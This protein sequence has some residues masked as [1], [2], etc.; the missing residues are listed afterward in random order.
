ML[1]NFHFVCGDLLF[2]VL[3]Q[4]KLTVVDLADWDRIRKYRWI[5][6]RRRK[7]FYACTG[8]FRYEGGLTLVYLHRV[9]TSY[10]EVDHENRDGLDNTQANLREGKDI[11]PFNKDLFS[12][13]TSGYKGVIWDSPRWEAK[14]TYH[15]IVENLGHFDDPIEAAREY[16]AAVR[17]YFPSGAYQNFP[18]NPRPRSPWFR[19]KQGINLNNTTGFK[20]VYPKN[21]PPTIWGARIRLNGK[22]KYLGTFRKPEDAA[23]RYD[24]AVKEFFPEGAYLNFG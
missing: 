12:N 15:G 4:D 17:E 13:N 24:L 2:I 18:D 8:D 14:I 7:K 23:R 1:K 6:H 22:Q 3:T 19:Q 9:I 5:T 11:N 16:D 21:N 10:V 20:G